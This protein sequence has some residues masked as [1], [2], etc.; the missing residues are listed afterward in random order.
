MANRLEC[1]DAEGKMMCEEE[2]DVRTKWLPG[3]TAQA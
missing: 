1:N 3:F 2:N